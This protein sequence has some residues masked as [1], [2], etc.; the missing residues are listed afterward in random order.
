MCIS[1]Q[2]PNYRGVDVNFIQTNATS[3]RKKEMRIR[4]AK[5]AL[6]TTTYYI[7]GP[8]PDFF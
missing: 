1:L 5:T 7:C 4:M 3:I 8:L 6:P 2:N